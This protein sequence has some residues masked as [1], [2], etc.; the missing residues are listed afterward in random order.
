LDQLGGEVVTEAVD[1]FVD[2]KP[3]EYRIYQIT[4]GFGG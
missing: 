3:F 2:L 1:S 4:D